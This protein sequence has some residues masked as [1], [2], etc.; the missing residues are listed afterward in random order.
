MVAKAEAMEQLE[1]VMDIYSGYKVNISLL[2][3][4]VS[5]AEDARVGKRV[6]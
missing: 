2:K 5:E 4:Y 1:A 3:T 6:T